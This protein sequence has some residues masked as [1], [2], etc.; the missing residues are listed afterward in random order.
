MEAN[1]LNIKANWKH[2]LLERLIKENDPSQ[3]MSRS[4]VFEREVKAAQGVQNWKAVQS[5]LV[6]LRRDE[7]IPVSTSFQA[8]Y[9]EET[10]RMLEEERN[11]IAEQLGLKVLQAQYFVQLL[12]ANY[13]Q[14]LKK[15]H[16][17]IQADIL[18][19]GACIEIPE[20]ARIF[21]EMIMTDR[22]CEEWKQIAE[23]LADWEFRHKK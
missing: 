16:A 17:S 4:A 10:A 22:N 6:N 19:D 11:D 12:Q 14:V 8:K 21:T 9:S 23:I 7:S 13:L 18:S 2:S 15:T 3:D 1:F 20:A 5:T